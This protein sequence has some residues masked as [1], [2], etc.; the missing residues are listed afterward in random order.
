MKEIGMLNPV[1]STKI[2]EA[3]MEQ[4]KVNVKT[5]E[6]KKGDK[7]PSERELSEK[8]QVSRTSVREALKS[9]SILGLIESKHGEGNFIKK[10][11]E[12]SLLEPLSI[13][14]LLLGNGNEEILEFRKIVEPECAAI[15]AQKISKEE[16][17]EIYDIMNE[18]NL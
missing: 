18:L 1:K 5:G 6:L 13:I 9:L 16:L 10:D 11:F 14:F 7:L 17:D 2:Y 12:D 15:A 3:V 8:L 4:I